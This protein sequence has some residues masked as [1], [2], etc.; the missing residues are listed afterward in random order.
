MNGLDMF[1]ILKLYYKFHHR[2]MIINSCLKSP[3]LIPIKCIL[4]GTFYVCLDNS[5]FI[6]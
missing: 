6:K 4:N 3:V 1:V 5:F 2:M